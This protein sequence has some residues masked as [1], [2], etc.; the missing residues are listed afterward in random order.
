MKDTASPLLASTRASRQDNIAILRRTA[1]EWA[2]ELHDTGAAERPQVVIRRDRLCIPVRAGRQSD[3][4]RGSVVLATSSTGSTVYMEPAALVPLNNA[5]A[6]LG[7]A[8]REEEDRILRELAAAV[9]A[10]E[11]EIK[12]VLAAATALDIAAARAK[13]AKWM[14]GVEPILTD[15]LLS[16]QNNDNNSEN[17]QNNSSLVCISGALH[18]ILMEPLLP[19]LSKP[20]LPEITFTSSVTDPNSSSLAGV[21]LVPELWTAITA[22]A[23]A[24]VSA[25]PPPRRRPRQTREQKQNTNESGENASSSASSLSTSNNSSSDDDGGSDE[26]TPH[27]ALSSLVPIDLLIPTGKTV[28]AVTGPNTGGKTASLKALGLLSLMAKSGLFLP[29]KRPPSTTTTTLSLP[30]EEEDP[31][32]VIPWFDR[33]LAD[34]GDGQNLQQSL[35]TFSGHVRRL[36]GVLQECTPCSLILLDEVGSG[37]DPGEGAALAAALLLR[38]ADGRAALTYAT[39]HHAELKEV[40]STHPA[41]INASVEFDI[42]SLKPTYRLLWGTSGDSNALA[43][44]EGLGF[45]PLVVQDAR[46][47]ASQLADGENSAAVRAAAL[48]AS[49]REQAAAAQVAAV[50][51]ARRRA[52]VEAELKAVQEELKTQQTEHAAAISKKAT[53][54]SNSKQKKEEGDAGGDGGID[55]TQNNI[56]KVLS[57][58]RNAKITPEAGE[59]ELRRIERR[60]NSSDSAAMTLTGLKWGSSSGSGGGSGSEE[61][62]NALAIAQQQRQAEGWI[63]QP[64]EF[65]QVLKMGGAIGT[66]TNDNCGGGGKISVR[67]GALTMQVRVTDVAPSST[68]PAPVTS[69]GKYAGGRRI[70]ATGMLSSSSSSSSIENAKN[71][72]ASAATVGSIL[73]VAVQTSRNTVDVRGLV[74]DDAVAAVEIALNDARPGSVV[75]AVHGVG[76]G[77]VRAAVL[78]AARRH[79]TMVKMEE[80]EASNGG[81]TVIYL[82]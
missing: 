58:V 72:S 10:G 41:F 82:K 80:A 2:R 32:P 24:A 66:V 42:E 31:P 19:T 79:P 48:H 36:R 33:I 49:L 26:A 54:K 69:T 65:V 63:P 52:V 21:N 60:L 22:E 29:I 62:S 64:G 25:V 14:G 71:R 7:A 17:I 51:A 27:D 11:K 73:G 6:A 9:A 28:V 1:D 12:A 38:L 4:P 35:S 20:R 13:H 46:E 23:A 18:P 59:K 44:A 61:E 15:T 40:A 56:R 53:S 5:E 81:C 39:T 37:T 47:V 57:D 67:I 3:L 74:P 78:D 16:A 45:D 30:T 75:F 76:T 34:V 8:E 68:A 55:I 77:R 50:E 70:K 43:V